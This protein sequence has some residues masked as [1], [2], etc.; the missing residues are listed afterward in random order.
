[1]NL[2]KIALNNNRT[3][4]MV[5]IIIV[6]AGLFGY[7]YLE[8]DSMPPYTV[9]IASVV[10]RF[11]GANPERV[12]S[13]ITEKLEEV[14]QEIPEVKTIESESR[15]GIS[16]ITVELKTE[17]GKNNLRNVW[18]EMRRKVKDVEPM[19]P[20]G[21]FGPIVKDEDIGVVHGI[22]LGL[23][24]DDISYNILEEYTEEIRD[25]LI[26]LPDA[27]KV[28]LGGIQQERIYIEYDDAQLA[29][30][31]LTSLKLKNII[32]ASNI[33]HPGGT[34]SL[35]NKSIILEPTGNFENIEDI[36]NTLVPTN[37]GTP[38]FLG[39]IAVVKKGYIQ[40]EE[41]IVRVNGKRAISLS[42]ALKDGANIVT[43][44]DEVDK[45]INEIN[46][47]LPIGL[48]LVRAA[49]Q[50]QI[51]NRQI[52]D[53]LKNLVQ[54]VLIVL[55]VMFIFLGFRT[56]SIV[57]ALV[58]MT[59]ISSL[60]LMNVFNVGLNKVSL[61]ALIISMG[62]LV[63]NAIVMSESIMV[64][65]E[66]GD[67][68]FQASVNSC[69]ILI[70][71][72]LTSTLTTS[73][74][75]L[76]F[77]LADTPMGEI[78]S[79]LFSVVTIALLSSWALTFTFVPLLSLYVIK[80]KKNNK[81][82]DK[83]ADKYFK[84]FNLWYNKVLCKVLKKPILFLSFI[85]TLL[86]LAIIS[87]QF[88]P[89]KLVPDSDRNLVTVDI[90]FPS[91]TNID[92]TTQTVQKIEKFIDD[93]LGLNADRTK[94]VQ[95]Y[96]AYIGVGPEPYDLGYFKGESSSN[97]AHMLLNT[98]GDLDNDY[99]IEILDNFCFNNI[100]DADIRVNRLSGAGA[101]GTPV[102]IRLFGN[103]PMVLSDLNEKVRA[104]LISM[105]GTKNITDDWGLK[106]K[107]LVVNI[108]ESKAR[109]V[110]LSN[111]EI[112]NALNTELSGFKV[113]DFR[114]GDKNLPILLKGNPDEEKSLEGLKGL[115]IFSNQLKQ[116]IPLE[117]VAEIKLEWQNPKIFRKDMVRVLTV[118][119]YIKT[120][121][122]A[123]EVIATIEPW[124]EEEQQLWPTGYT[125]ELGGEDESKI[126]NIGAVFANLPYSAFLII[127][128]LIMQFNSIRKTFIVFITIPFGIIGAVFG[129]YIGG[130][131][132]S[133]FGI[134]G[135]IALA[136][137][138]VNNAII[139]I[140]RI[141]V[142][143]DS[144]PEISDQNA[145]VLAANHKFRPALLTTLTTSL[146]MVP[147]WLGGGLLWEPLSLAIIFGLLFATIII[148]LFVPVLYRLLYRI[149]FKD[150]V[151][152]K[153]IL[154]HH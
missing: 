86:I 132:I 71:P 66:N 140:D 65:M 108:D 62:L 31:G 64:Q 59:I 85:I 16:I 78:S 33:L 151:F 120:G 15:T 136:G 110:G 128:L 20:D 145:I 113:G 23:T 131:F 72:L 58:P 154:E 61:A 25:E 109:K 94:G 75:F 112:A 8:Q 96:S 1:M 137:I 47:R 56:G 150:Y 69:K 52:S 17:V 144:N 36:K 87:M 35:A 106:I 10:T 88:L 93:S 84:Q 119:T 129:W 21:I 63:D 118:G 97:Y 114:K 3:T 105:N 68:V 73:F 107:K 14:I 5:F 2:T 76:A 55:T 12:E 4:I 102:E 70:I 130:S 149:S 148:L 79:P 90:K 133:F 100:P 32:S 103:N 26:R 13:L 125:Y 28:K 74:A 34:V 99:V 67:S 60:F 38:V 141:T 40:P 82:Q 122:T 24:S 153:S 57:A 29:N 37:N 116:N 127:L 91:G 41:S 49:S 101:A 143:K 43:L 123:A 152:D 42:I 126:E 111:F 27:A 44:G 46:E 11:P 80:I 9:R 138:L 39:D 30:Y 81:E 19:L 147:L 92:I 98:S 142:E 50:D 135:V 117:Q 134:L 139:L 95:D 104:K 77:F 124:I 6:V 53:F 115:S 22:I 54:S 51:V 7:Q 89:F 146:G 83:K 18:D 121:Y 45:K 48:D